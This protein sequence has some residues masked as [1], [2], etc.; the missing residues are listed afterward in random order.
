MPRFSFVEWVDDDGAV[1]TADWRGYI[2]AEEARQFEGARSV[3]LVVVRVDS[4]RQLGSTEYVE[5]CLVGRE[6]WAVVYQR[7]RIIPGPEPRR[8]KG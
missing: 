8:E 1:H 6:A 7:I 3:R 5:G 2:G 4:G